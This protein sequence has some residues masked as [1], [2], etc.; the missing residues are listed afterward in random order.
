M[1][2]EQALSSDGLEGMLSS[3]TI[4]LRHVPLLTNVRAGRCTS[5]FRAVL[6][7]SRS[8]PSSSCPSTLVRDAV[9]VFTVR[10]LIAFY[11]A[12]IIA[13][14]LYYGAAMPPASLDEEDDLEQALALAEE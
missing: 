10:R 14:R 9:S 7:N 1:D 6:C 12:A 13:Q 8:A 11:A 5:S 4:R 3:R 2:S